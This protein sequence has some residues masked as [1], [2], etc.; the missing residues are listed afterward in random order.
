MFVDEGDHSLRVHVLA[1]HHVRTVLL[2]HDG[3]QVLSVREFEP[4]ESLARVFP[5]FVRAALEVAL[6]THGHA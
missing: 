3:V 1:E 5:A 2:E 4:L 6:R